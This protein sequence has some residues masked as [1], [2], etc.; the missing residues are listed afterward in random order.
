MAFTSMEPD[1]NPFNANSELPFVLDDL[2]C[3][4]DEGNLLQCLPDENC[5]SSENAGVR[6]QRK[7][8]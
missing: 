5:G 4:G 8:K 6:C 3:S 2:G 1:S 7:G